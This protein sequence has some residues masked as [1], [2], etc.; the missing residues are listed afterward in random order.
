MAEYVLPDNNR[1]WLVNVNSAPPAGTLLSISSQSD[2]GKLRAE[3]AVIGTYSDILT[4]T[5]TF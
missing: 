2:A 5:V 4:V 1:E 3:N